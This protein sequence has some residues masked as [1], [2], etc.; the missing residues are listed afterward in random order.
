MKISNF[1]QLFKISHMILQTYHI[2]ILNC[3]VSHYL[4]SSLTLAGIFL[5][6]SLFEFHRWKGA[7]VL[8]M[9][10]LPEHFQMGSSHTSLHP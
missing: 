6:S 7:S 8:L 3:G 2:E 5:S 9:A 4:G 10:D 1:V